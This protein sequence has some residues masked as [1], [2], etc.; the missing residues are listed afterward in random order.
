MATTNTLAG[1]NLA[2][3]SQITLKTLKPE[4]FWLKGI[5]TD[6]SDDLKKS[7][8]SVT[9]RIAGTPTVIDGNTAAQ[10]ITGAQNAS[11][12]SRTVTLGNIRTARYEFTDIEVGLSEVEL[13]RLFIPQM[14]TAIAMDMLTTTFNLITAAN[15]TKSTTIASNEYDVAKLAQLG[16]AM[17][18]DLIPRTPRYTSI[19]NPTY[20]ANLMSDPAFRNY[21]YSDTT[22][23][24]R[25]AQTMLPVSGFMVGE[26]NGTIPTNSENLVG[27]ACNPNALIVAARQLPIPDASLSFGQF[28]NFTEPESGL[29]LQMRLRYDPNGIY[30]LECFSWFGVAVGNA[31]MLYRIKSS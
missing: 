26:Y 4:L 14:V 28:I 29:P 27:I 3:I 9:T 15:F 12:V 19:V 20:Y 8:A 7:G 11:T 24:I 6:F 1:V 23:S 17:Y 10:R 22:D 2:K 31:D 13:Q 30:I 21:S 16:A 5:V 25:N 18:T